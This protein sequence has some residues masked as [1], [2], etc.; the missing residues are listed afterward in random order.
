MA[1]LRGFLVIVLSVLWLAIAPAPAIAQEQDA[2]S[3]IEYGQWETLARRAELSIETGRASDISLETLRAQLDDWRQRFNAVQSAQSVKVRSLRSQLNALGP[4][5]EG[6]ALDEFADERTRL[7]SELAAAEA[8]QKKANLAFTEAESLI[9]S[10]DTLLRARQAETLFKRTKTPI[11]PTLWPAA[12]EAVAKSAELL[13]QELASTFSNKDALQEAKRNLPIFLILLLPGLVLVTRGRHVADR[14][15]ER[16]TSDQIVGVRWLLAYLFSLGQIIL[17]LLGLVLIT[18]AIYATGLPGLRA[19]ALLTDLP[20]AGGYLLLAMWLGARAFP[21]NPALR[22]LLDLSPEKRT[23]GRLMAFVLGWVLVFHVY[24]DEM[25][26]YDDWSDEVRAVIYLPLIV[27]GALGIAQIGRLLMLHA[28]HDAGDEEQESSESR[29]LDSIV[30]IGGRAV[31]AIAVIGVGLSVIGFARASQG[32]IIPM[33]LSLQLVTF[34]ALLQRLLS[35]IYGLFARDETKVQDSLLLVFTGLALFVLALP[36]LALIWGARLSDLHEIWTRI[37]YG[38]QLGDVRIS[39]MDVLVLVMV[40]AIGYAVTRLSQGIIQ[41]TVLPRTRID[42][43]GQTAIVS[44]LGYIGIFLSAIIAITSAGINLSNVALL[45]GALS[46][47]IGFG[48]QTIVQNFVSGIILLIERPITEG[49]WIEVNGQ[50]GYVRDISVRATRIETFDRTDVIIPNGDLVSGSVT[51][52]TRGNTIG[53]VI[54]PVGVAYGTDPRKVE[55]VLREIA[56]AHPMVLVNPPPNVVFQ[57]FG[58][59]SL[60]FEI[61]AILRDVNWMLT[62]RSEMNFEIARRFEEEGI[63]IPFA[64]RDVWIR[65]PEALVGGKAA[66]PVKPDP[67]EPAPE[68]TKPVEMTEA[69]MDN[70]PDGDGDADGD[71]R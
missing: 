20:L 35:L 39:P 29:Y 6:G 64:Q 33:I 60:D 1:A 53:R 10:L 17:P 12:I 14:F 4:A 30:S 19:D 49:D 31:M 47:G 3:A 38:L 44:G 13:L 71:A 41:N 52:Y 28:R 62:V 48:L 32:V 25:A 36:L 59:D 2:I 63:E 58:A 51:N 24:L 54:V 56:E 55:R 22:P 57:G 61:R 18:A 67:R 45:A 66:E 46:V 26:K 69:D 37:T 68:I 8:P 23:E 50:M 43:G 5:P 34:L 40:F 27:V 7:Q 70:A 15:L 16:L 9:Y 65:N 21:K 42:K 11:N